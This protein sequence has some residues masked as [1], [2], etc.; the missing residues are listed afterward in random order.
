MNQSNRGVAHTQKN[1]PLLVI[2][3]LDETLLRHCDRGR[4]ARIYLTHITY[5]NTLSSLPYESQNHFTSVLDVSTD[6]PITS[7]FR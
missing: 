4:G 5:R 7:S 3:I 6:L 2:L 1:S